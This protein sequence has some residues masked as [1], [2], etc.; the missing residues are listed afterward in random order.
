METS[1]KTNEES[2]GFYKH[3][4]NELDLVR[5]IWHKTLSTRQYVCTC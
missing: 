4:F 3:G 1:I 2:K 5:A